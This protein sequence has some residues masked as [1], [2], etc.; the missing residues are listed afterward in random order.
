MAAESRAIL[1]GRN[2]RCNNGLTLASRENFWRRLANT[3]VTLTHPHPRVTFRL[4]PC[5]CGGGGERQRSFQ[6][7]LGG[8]MKKTGLLILLWAVAASARRTRK[9]RS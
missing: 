4:S 6:S 3:L 5:V 1:Q 2:S 7:G 9:P 8:K